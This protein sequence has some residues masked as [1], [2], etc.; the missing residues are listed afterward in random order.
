MVI[1]KVLAIENRCNH[2]RIL[3]VAPILLLLLV[4]LLKTLYEILRLLLILCQ[5]LLHFRTISLILGVNLCKKFYRLLSHLLVHLEFPICLFWS[6]CVLSKKH[7][8]AL[9]I[10]WSFIFVCHQV[11]LDKGWVPK[12]LLLSFWLNWGIFINLSER[13]LSWLFLGLRARFLISPVSPLSS[14]YN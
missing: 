7:F 5:T 8:A 12:A 6:T 10:V 9:Y 3:C 2:V 11:A 4:R 13:Y 14:M 1:I